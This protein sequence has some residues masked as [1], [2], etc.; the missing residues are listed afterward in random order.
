MN[1]YEANQALGFDMDQRDYGVG[2]QILKE[3]GIRKCAL[4]R[5][6]LPNGLAFLVMV[7]SR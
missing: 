2:A 5:T 1:T 3:L 4:C 7:G 6:I